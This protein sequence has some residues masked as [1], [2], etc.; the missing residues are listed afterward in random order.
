MKA[1]MVSVWDFDRAKIDRLIHKPSILDIP[2]NGRLKQNSLN[3]DNMLNNK[4]AND[5]DMT[6][7]AGFTTWSQLKKS[8]EF[9]QMQR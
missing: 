4:T 8:N 5:T 9:M 2:E 6:Q 7:S 1:T 3:L